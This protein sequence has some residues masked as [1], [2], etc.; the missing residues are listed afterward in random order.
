MA[1]ENLN[2]VPGWTVGSSN[3]AK[4]HPSF[5]C[6]H[7]ECVC[8]RARVRG[9]GG[10]SSVVTERRT[11]DW[12]VAG[13]NQRR[14]GGRFFFSRVSFLCRLQALVYD[15]LPST[16]AVFSY[17]IGSRKLSAN[18]LF[19]VGTHTVVCLLQ[20]TQI[21]QGV[22]CIAA[23]K[24]YISTNKTTIVW[25]E[26][27]LFSFLCFT[28]DGCVSYLRACFGPRLDHF[29]LRPQ[30]RGGLLWTGG[31]GGGGGTKEW[32]LDLGYRPKK[33][34]ET[35]DRRQNNGSVKVKVQGF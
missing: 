12:K 26:T 29:A 28:R 33:T 23:N 19:F 16:T 21:K 14:N 3:F 34:G 13:T 5:A 7:C 8:A 20:T 30:K 24:V 1:G 17:A 18:E 4:L 32:R 10:D 22:S 11:R 25:I 9:R 31:G 6:C 27:E 35:V 2:Q 15:I